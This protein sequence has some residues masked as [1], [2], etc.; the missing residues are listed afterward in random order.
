MLFR[1]RNKTGALDLEATEMAIRSAMHQAGASALTQ[2]LQFG[3]PDPDQRSVPCEC[4]QQAH[5]KELRRK[6][7]LTVVGRV[8]V[9][10]PYYLCPQCSHGQHPSDVE[11]GIDHLECSPGVR[12]MEAV[13]GSNAPFAQ[14]CEPMKLLAGLEVTAKA[15]ERTAEAIGGDIASL[16]QTEIV[17]AKQLVLPEVAKQS[18]PKLYVLMDATGVPAVSAETK[19]CNGKVEG[20]HAHT[21]ESKLGCVFTQTTL[22]E[23]GRPVRD[24]DSTTYVGAIETAEEFGLRLYTEAWHRGWE[25]A[26]LKVVLGDGA[27]WIWNLADRHFPGAVQIVDLYHARQHVWSIATL[28]Y[29]SDSAKQKRWV[30][31][32]QSELDLGKIE[33]LVKRIRK[34]AADNIEINHKLTA[35]A[36][37]FERNAPRMRYPDFRKQGLFVGSG[38]IEAGC[39]SVIASRLKCSGMF[40]T[41]RGANAVIAL[42]CCLLNGRFE[43]YWEHRPAA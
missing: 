4:G 13:V 38:V 26:D 12:R 33:K 34:L 2:L 6:T 25:W 29:A 21:R 28:L 16:Q 9:Q 18:I 1:D 43:D 14:A 17:Q 24:P 39:K 30:M 8:Q 19:D 41:V 37:Y 11:L 27:I 36:D 31:A 5:Y 35:E 7:I 10:R 42:R 22:D 32:A 3:E 15:V 20:Q 40:W 23:E